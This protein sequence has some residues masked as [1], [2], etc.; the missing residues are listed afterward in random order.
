MRKYCEGNWFRFRDQCL[1]T[2]T[3][4]CARR[5]QIVFTKNP[6]LR[7]FDGPKRG[8]G[9]VAEWRSPDELLAL[10][11]KLCLGVRQKEMRVIAMQ[12]FVP[13]LI[14]VRG[15]HSIETFETFRET[16]LEYRFGSGCYLQRFGNFFLGMTFKAHLKSNL[17]L[18]FVN[19]RDGK[20]EAD[21]NEIDGGACCGERHDPAA[22][23]SA[24]ISNPRAA[25][26]CNSLRLSHGSHGVVCE[27]IE[28]LRVFVS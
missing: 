7:G 2:A 24:L 1:D 14:A 27:G 11:P 16:A 12:V 19:G 21:D 4:L 22:L 10:L 15:P 6:Q 9:I 3:C 18:V 5:F 13:G 8:H 28:I 25:R 23:T 20:P 17:L 26:A